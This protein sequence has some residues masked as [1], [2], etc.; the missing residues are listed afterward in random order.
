MISDEVAAD[1]SLSVPRAVG[2]FSEFQFLN[3]HLQI[4][5]TWRWMSSDEV[6]LIFHYMCRMVGFFSI[7]ILL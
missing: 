7:E 3:F 1:I 5:L 4:S 6:G 2:F